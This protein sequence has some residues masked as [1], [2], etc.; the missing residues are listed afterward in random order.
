MLS[1]QFYSF[2]HGLFYFFKGQPF[3]HNPNQVISNR[4]SR[5]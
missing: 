3:N 2:L 5:C 4:L 1:G